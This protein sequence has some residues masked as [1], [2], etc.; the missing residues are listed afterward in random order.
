MQKQAKIKE[1]DGKWVVYTSDESR[2]LGRHDSREKALRQE[3]A[4]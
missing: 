3:R 1:E 4:I 2:V